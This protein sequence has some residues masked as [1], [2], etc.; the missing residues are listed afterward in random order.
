MRSI[1]LALAVVLTVV[2]VGARAAEPSGDAS[3]GAALFRTCA[4]CH[5]LVPDRNM[6]GPSLAGIWGRKAGSLESFERYSSALRASGVV[7]DAK[8]LDAWLKSPAGFIPDSHMPFAGIPNA[9]QR[10]D[11]I[12]YLKGASAGK[13]PAV[14]GNRNGMGGM[15][16]GTEPHFTDLK[17]VGAN[18]QVRAIRI[19][20]DSYF[21]TTA[22]GKTTA[23]WEPNLR[24]K[25]DS[26]AVGPRPG[27]PVLLGAGMIGDR[28]F[29]VFAAPDE[30]SGFIKHRCDAPK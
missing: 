13:A 15:M 28:A 10:A 14:A 25:T 1:S 3:R 11:L 29:V 27:A 8:A 19:C 24:F 22:D 12:A 4:A 16:G 21:V 23:F 17:K 20:R 7:W 6:T 5:S 9:Q 26:S 30:I 2:A 18:Q